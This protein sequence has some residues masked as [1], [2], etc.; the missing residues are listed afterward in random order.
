[1]GP[2][3]TLWSLVALLQKWEF[4]SHYG[5]GVDSASNRNEYQ[6]DFLGVNAAGALGWQT[7]HI[8]VPL[9]WNLGTL[10]SWNPL[11]YSRPVTGLI[12]LNFLEPSGPL[13]ACNGRF[14]L[15]YTDVIPVNNNTNCLCL[16]II[17]VHFYHFL[18]VLIPLTSLSPS[19]LNF[20]IAVL[21]FRGL[22]MIVNFQ[23][24]DDL[25]YVT[26]I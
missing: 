11:G 24:D 17:T 13:Q 20:T 5:P 3:H 1:M 21:P 10:T 4:R 12:Y 19:G 15:P 2:G 18:C 9:S 6:E 23:N 8:P 25:L 26:K 7:Y 16:S 22:F 14:T